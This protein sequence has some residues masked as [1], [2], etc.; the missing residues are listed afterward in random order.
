MP[1]RR[2]RKRYRSSSA[3]AG[4][5]GDRTRPPTEDF[6]FPDGGL[7]GQLCG[8]WETASRSDLLLVR[9]AIKEDWPVPLERRRPLMKAVLAPLCRNDKPVRLALAV[10]KLAIAADLHDLDQLEAERKAS[11]RK[12]VFAACLTLSTTGLASLPLSGVCHWENR[13]GAVGYTFDPAL[14]VLHLNYTLADPARQQQESLAYLVQLEARPTRFGGQR[15]WFLCPL[16]DRG[17]PCNSR[18]SNLYL[19]PGQRHFGCRHCHR[20]TYASRQR[21]QR[22]R[23]R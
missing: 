7:G 23:G 9:K 10:C 21:S 4:L 19:P 2:T 13:S 15:W 6:G 18:V 1:S 5:R 22:A 20:L 17:Q 16:M 11:A 14:S 8:D 12:V 3:D